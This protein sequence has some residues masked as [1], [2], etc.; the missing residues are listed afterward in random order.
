MI[1]SESQEI[2]PGIKEIIGLPTPA[3]VPI[4]SLKN[5]YI[6]FYRTGNN[7]RPLEKYFEISNPTSD[8]RMVINKCKDY[9]DQTGFRF[10]KV[11]RFL[12][13]MD[14]DILKVRTQG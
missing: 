9:C 5:L 11:E 8:M 3:Q 2:K 10:V 1:N 12:S 14:E 4:S 7:P 13:D 6:L